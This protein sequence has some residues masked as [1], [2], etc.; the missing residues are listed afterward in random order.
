MVAEILGAEQNGQGQGRETDPDQTEQCRDIAGRGI[1]RPPHPTGQR[2]HGVDDPF[3]TEEGKAREVAGRENGGGLDADDEGGT[4]HRGHDLRDQPRALRSE[5]PEKPDGQQH[6]E[7]GAQAR[8][9]EYDAVTRQ[10]SRPVD[11]GEGIDERPGQ[12]HGQ[13]DRRDGDGKDAN[14]EDAPRRNRRR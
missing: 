9:P 1:G 14:G 6:G 4:D 12:Y 5:G 7:G 2:R 8:Q 11:I 10:P 13:Q 3:R